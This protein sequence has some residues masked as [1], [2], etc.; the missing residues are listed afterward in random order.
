MKWLLLLLNITQP[1]SSREVVEVDRVE[2]NTVC[3]CG[4]VRF[5][6]IILWRWSSQLHQFHVAEWQMLPT[7][8]QEERGG[9]IR[10][11]NSEGKTFR[12]KPRAFI[13]TRGIDTELANRKHFPV[14]ERVPYFVCQNAD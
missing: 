12:V 5:T 10:W 13:V 2:I 4:E 8:F 7:G 14:S 9:V 11:R 6:Q 1:W 3:E